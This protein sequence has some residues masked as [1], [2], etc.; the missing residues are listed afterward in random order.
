MINQI[1]QKKLDKY[2]EAVECRHFISYNFQFYDIINILMSM[3]NKEIE[4][5]GFN[6][7]WQLIFGELFK[8][9]FE[10]FIKT[11]KKDMNKRDFNFDFKTY[12]EDNNEI[13]RCKENLNEG[14]QQV[15]PLLVKHLNIT[16]IKIITLS[17]L[18]GDLGVNTMNL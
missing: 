3:K 11:Y 5:N 1:L 7:N 10:L 2:F 12:M 8:S 6:K 15:F 13:K 18:K 16:P 17:G 9:S 14:I 4:V